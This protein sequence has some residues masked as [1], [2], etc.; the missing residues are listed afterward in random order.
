MAEKYLRLRER[1]TVKCNHTL[2]HSALKSQG[3]SDF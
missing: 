2:Q 3:L 1:K